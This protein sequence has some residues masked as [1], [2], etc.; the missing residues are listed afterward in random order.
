[1]YPGHVHTLHCHHVLTL[2]SPSIILIIQLFISLPQD[3]LSQQILFKAIY[4]WFIEQFVKI[5]ASHLADPLWNYI[6]QTRLE[7][8]IKLTRQDNLLCAA[9]SDEK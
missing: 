3:N 7:Q 5:A 1:M 4:D 6:Q 2:Y 9:V 8:L